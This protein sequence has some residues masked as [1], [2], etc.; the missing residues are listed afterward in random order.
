MSKPKPVCTWP[1]GVHIIN[2]VLDAWEIRVEARKVHG[3]SH[4]RAA[5]LRVLC[6]D[7]MNEYMD[8]M[9]GRTELPGQGGLW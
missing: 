6:A 7:H 2:H 4:G 1:D 3:Q 9:Q 8:S 5:K